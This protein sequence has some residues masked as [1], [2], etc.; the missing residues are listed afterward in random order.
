MNQQNRPPKDSLP[1]TLLPSPEMRRM[2]AA[3]CDASD[4]L[5]AL[6]H[7]NRLL[8]L[9]LL[10]ESERTVTE[11]E[12]LLALRQPAVSQQLARLRQDGFVTT[13]REGKTI[14]YRLADERVRNF[15][16]LIHSTFCPP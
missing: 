1:D 4:Y 8:L 10:A 15:I 5:K 7:A 9:C 12:G 6:A 16:Q 14:H 3:A 2:M 13:R 11:L